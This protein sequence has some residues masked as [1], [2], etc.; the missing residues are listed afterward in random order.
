MLLPFLRKMQQCITALEEEEKA[1]K[2]GENH[3]HASTAGCAECLHTVTA[4][5]Q[6]NS[7]FCNLPLIKA[8]CVL[9]TMLLFFPSH[10]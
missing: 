3:N 9:S 8:W 6:E 1:R 7:S 5:T 2:K 4:G 10:K